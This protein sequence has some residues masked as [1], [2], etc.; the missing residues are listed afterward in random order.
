MTDFDSTWVQGIRTLLQQGLFAKAVAHT[1]RAL[2][3]PGNDTNGRLVQLHG[4]TLY[5]NGEHDAARHAFEST[6]L[7]SPLTAESLLALADLY[8]KN[9][10][11][12]DAC[13]SLNIL[14]ED[15]DTVPEELLPRIAGLLGK[16]GE[17]RKALFVCYRVIDNDP[18]CDE[19]I[20]A[21]AHYMRKLG[22]APKAVIGM[23]RRAVSLAPDN[24]NYRRSLAATLSINGDIKAA[25]ELFTS[26]STDDICCK[27]CLQLMANVFEQFGDT[28]R[29]AECQ[30]RLF[31][32]DSSAS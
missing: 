12:K 24:C 18:D 17:T 4:L 21:S 7:L 11:Q 22:Y 20:F 8:I 13:V 30:G 29:L 6:L 31:E 28:E 15:I 14:V 23:M 16:V 9:S 2:R 25:Y 3:C 32:I 26:I 19:A 27:N 1:E 5:I 10:Q